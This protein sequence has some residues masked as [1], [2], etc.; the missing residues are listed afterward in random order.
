MGLADRV[1]LLVAVWLFA[2]LPLSGFAASPSPSD[3]R[4]LAENAAGTEVLFGYDAPPSAYHDE[5]GRYIGMLVDFL[6]E[7]EGDLGVRFPRRNFATWGELVEYARTGDHFLIV[8]MAANPERLKYL[9]FTAPLV[10]ES[11]VIVTR[12]SS[13]DVTLDDL[14]GARVCSVRDYT[15]NGYLAENFPGLVVDLVPTNLDGLRAVSDGR[16]DA[17]VVCQMYGSHL[18]EEQGITNLKFSG[19]TGF[20]NPLA[21]AVADQD[22]ALLGVVDRAVGRISP[23]RR[24]EIYRRWVSATSAG[25]SGRVLLW[26]GVVAAVGLVLA[27]LLWVWSASLKRQVDNQTRH[28][29]ASR[30]RFQ[31]LFHNISDPVLIQDAGTGLIL[32]ANEAARQRYHLGSGDQDGCLGAGCPPPE[33]WGPV[34]ERIQ[35]LSPGAQL[36]YETV[37]TPPNEPGFPVEVHGR[38]VDFDGTP[39]LMNVCRDLTE[40]MAMEAERRA[41]ELQLQRSQKTTAMGVLAGG[42]AHDLN[43]M[44]TPVLGYAE[45]LLDDLPDLPDQR[46]A[47]QQIIQAGNKAKNLV[48]RLLAMGRQQPLAVQALDLNRVV[49]DFES[50]LRKGLRNDVRLDLDL[51]DRPMAVLADRG[52]LEQILLNLTQNAQ[53]SLAVGGRLVMGTRDRVLAGGEPGLP[54]DL[55]GGRYIVL[56]VRD[57]GSGMTPDTLEHLFEP[58]YSTK[59]ERGTGLG[60]AVV[61]GITRQHGGHIQVTSKLGGGSVFTIYLPATDLEPETAVEELP[62]AA[63]L[64]GTETILLVDDDAQVRRLTMTVLQ[65]LGFHVLPA[66]SG[67]LALEVAA[68]WQGNIDLLMTDVVM[69]GLNGKEVHAALRQRFPRLAVLYISGYTGQVIA[70]RG[71]LEDGVLLLQKPFSAKDLGAMVRRALAGS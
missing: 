49:L 63:D 13:P 69:P 4:W 5:N 34:R 29:S 64:T 18:I 71:I 51:A 70:Q 68:A 11:Y 27:G 19:D 28:L 55:E 65:R 25:F 20:F 57:N 7:I 41:H 50:L 38:T 15:V 30:H 54:P 56:T 10:Q 24:K 17:M 45:M 52:Q 26:V 14:I 46:H 53:D 12:S 43:N 42:V 6:G 67:D 58:F 44:L 66:E 22:T 37:H 23:Q 39:V 61:H 32:E 36:I 3:S 33:D 9:A 60:L 1:S 8:G 35:S 62:I 40:R 59:G 48:K 2:G 21:C 31:T 47:V 16:F